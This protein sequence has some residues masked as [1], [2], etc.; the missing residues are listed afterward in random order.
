MLDLDPQTD[1]DPVDDL[2]VINAELE[3]YS[4]ELAS[5]PQ[6]VVANKVDLFEP[7]APRLAAI[8]RHCRSA[9]QPFHAISAVTGAGLPELL[10]S[11]AHR[12]EESGWL[13]A[14]S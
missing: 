14:A 12:L 4:P 13:R 7:G 2:A 5:R 8:E 6:I 9:G 10:R 11:I 1:R 3:A